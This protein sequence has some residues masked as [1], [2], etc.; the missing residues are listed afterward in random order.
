MGE[1]Q[2]LQ[3]EHLCAE[4]TDRDIQRL[5]LLAEQ[6]HFLL[7]IVEPLLLTLTAFERSHP[8]ISVSTAC[9]EHMGKSR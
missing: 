6:F 7:Q 9:R 4:R 3:V 8:V 2:R 5:V 1:E